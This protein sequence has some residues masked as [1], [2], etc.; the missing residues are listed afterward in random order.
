MYERWN[1]KD[2]DEVI[3]EVIGLFKNLINRR[4][5]LWS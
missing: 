3:E 2:D 1:K 4:N 5:E